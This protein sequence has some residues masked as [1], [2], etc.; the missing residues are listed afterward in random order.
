MTGARLHQGKVLLRLTGIAD[1]TAAEKLRGQTVE[2]PRDEA[3]PLD[4]DEFY[5]ADLIGASVFGSDGERIGRLGDVLQTTGGN[6]TAEL[7]LK[8]RS[9]DRM[10]R[11]KSRPCGRCSCPSGRILR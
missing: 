3:Q 1:R 11:K 5:I 8:A 6:D 7:Q 10:R 2:I 4:E 9:S